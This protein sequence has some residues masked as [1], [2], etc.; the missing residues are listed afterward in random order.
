MCEKER[1]KNIYMVIFNPRDTILLFFS[2]GMYV[3]TCV[4]MSYDFD[5]IKSV[6][7]LQMKYTFLRSNRLQSNVLINPCYLFYICVCINIYICLYTC[8]W[9]NLFPENCHQ[10]CYIIAHVYNGFSICY[11]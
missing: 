3:Y 4:K 5:N 2:D 7:V 9:L 11:L 10:R 6:F 1:K 8:Q